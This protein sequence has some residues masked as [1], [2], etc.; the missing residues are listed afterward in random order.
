MTILFQVKELEG[1]T[2]AIVSLEEKEATVSFDPDT[3]TSD[4]LVKFV[5]NIAEK[6]NASLI[7]EECIVFIEGMSCQS[8]VRCVNKFGLV[9]HF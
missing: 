2:D 7:S 9:Q 8:C 4:D 5:E 6:F 1:V 3:L